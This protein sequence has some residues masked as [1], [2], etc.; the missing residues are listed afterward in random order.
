MVLGASRIDEIRVIAPTTCPTVRRLLRTAHAPDH[1]GH[2]RNLQLPA[3]RLL[4]AG[5]LSIRM[6][7]KTAGTAE[8]CQL[9]FVDTV[10][11]L[12]ILVSA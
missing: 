12:P 3:R 1:L 2:R 6:D 4:K 7:L 10:T 11:S 5:K 9:A 8:R